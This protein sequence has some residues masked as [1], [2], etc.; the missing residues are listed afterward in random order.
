MYLGANHSHIFEYLGDGELKGRTLRL[1]GN[2]GESSGLVLGSDQGLSLTFYLL[3]SRQLGVC[4]SLSIFGSPKIFWLD[5]TQ[6]RWQG[7]N[8]ATNS[9]SLLNK[10]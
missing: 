7:Y 9:G 6:V 4:E 2:E 3:V 8:N 10:L 5:S 1:V